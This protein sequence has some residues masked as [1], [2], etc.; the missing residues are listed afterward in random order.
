MT[1][2]P[3]GPTRKAQRP[4]ESPRAGCLLHLGWNHP[5]IRI[6]RKDDPAGGGTRGA[7]CLD[8]VAPFGLTPEDRR[9]AWGP[10]SLGVSLYPGGAAVAKRGPR[11]HLPV[12]CGCWWSGGA[13]GGPG[14]PCWN[15]EFAGP[16]RGPRN[17]PVCVIC[18]LCRHSVVAGLGRTHEF[19]PGSFCELGVSPQTSRS[20]RL[21]AG[22]RLGPSGPCVGLRGAALTT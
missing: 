2:R 22:G 4:P 1:T 20:H 3:T 13:L 11:F 12:V 21:P 19:H 17:L 15:D 5:R 10:S 18:H 16:S 9:Q 7:A 6:Y 8:M 14:G